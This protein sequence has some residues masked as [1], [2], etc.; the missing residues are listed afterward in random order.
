MQKNLLFFVA[1]MF[2]IFTSC[3]KEE[4]NPIAADQPDLTQELESRS[5]NAVE[6]KI[7]KANA[8]Q[9][10][11]VCVDVTTKKFDNILAF[12][13]SLAWDPAV[14]SFSEVNNFSLPGLS[15]SSFANPAADRLTTSWFNED[16]AGIT[17]PNNHTLYSVCFTV[18]GT[19]GDQSDLDFTDNP[20][21]IEV[22][23]GDFNELPTSFKSGRVKV[24]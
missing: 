17:L 14:L 11:Q 19:S 20:T 1:S 15:S 10:D 3:S 13:Y 22:I 24:K 4:L 6:F 23:D 18:S 5:S 21:A 12:Q 8:N 9:G 7:G 16:L 2:F